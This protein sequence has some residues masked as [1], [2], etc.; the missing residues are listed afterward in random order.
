MPS[1][2]FHLPF[3]AK[4]I[5]AG[6]LYHEIGHHYHLRL[7]HGVTKNQREDFADEYRKK[8]LRRTFYWWLLLLRP[9]RPLIHRLR[10]SRKLWGHSLVEGPGQ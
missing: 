2:F 5:L 7:T 9:L 1:I 4:F 10:N 3:L 8:M 6:V